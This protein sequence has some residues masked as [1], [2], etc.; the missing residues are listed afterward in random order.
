MNRLQAGSLDQLDNTIGRP[1]YKRTALKPGILHFGIG[2]FHRA[3]QA[4]YTDD[5]VALCGGD[6]GI[7]GVSLRSNT[8]ARQLLPQDCLYS[9][10]S[11]D[12]ERSELRIIGVIQ[13]VIVAPDNSERVVSAIADPAIKIITLTITE[14]GYCLA[15]DGRSLDVSNS[16]IRADLE[17]PDAPLSAIGLLALGLHQRCVQSGAP[18]TLISCDNLS[19]NSKRLKT[20]LIDYLSKSFSDTVEWLAT[21]V[22]FPCS[23]VDRIVPAMTDE[24]RQQ[25]ALVLGVEDAAAVQTECFNQW[26][27]ED[28]FAAERP[29]WEQAG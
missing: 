13:D 12:A 16:Q 6:W 7:I 28:H 25:Q 29:A 26:I 10:L 19:E 3:H 9:V 1:R 14:K 17:H 15:A 20:V 11:Q 4:V 18:I 22:A 8:V 5:A 27:I 24:R 21:C 2:A 23:M